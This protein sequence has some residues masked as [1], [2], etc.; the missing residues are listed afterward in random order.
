MKKTFLSLLALAAMVVSSNAQVRQ[1]SLW[2]DNGSGVFGQISASLVT[3]PQT[4]QLPATGGTLAVDVAGG[5]LPLSGGTMTGAID[6]GTKNISNG[7]IFTATSFVGA[8][9]GN[10]STATALATARNINGVA[11]DGTADITVTAAAGTLTGATLASNVLASSL[12]SVGTLT[13][14]TMGGD[15]TL[16]AHD[17]TSTGTISATTFTG[18]LNG[19]A[20]TATSAGKLTTARNINGVAFDGTADITVTADAGTLTGTALNSTVV[21]SSLTSVGTLT[22]LTVGG[23][24]TTNGAH[25]LS[26]MT[27]VVAANATTIDDTHEYYIIPSNAG[28]PVAVTITGTTTGRL[29]IVK[30]LNAAPT[31][32]AIAVPP[33]STALF[34]YDG[35]AWQPLF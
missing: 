32:G 34:V 19:N 7:G 23:T 17:L 9:T 29:I 13:G 1:T 6:M 26:T 25:I 27:Q 33:G 35:A 16:G 15:I 28:T 24:L 31:S 20:N 3:T 5:Y 8:L 12:T 2:I 14:L 11:F 22:S 10:A 4:Y 18:A 21:G 30:N